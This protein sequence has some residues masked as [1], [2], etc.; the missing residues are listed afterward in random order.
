[1]ENLRLLRN[2]KG[3]TIMDLALE[4][5]VV[6]STIQQYETGINEPNIEMLIKLADYFGVTIDY[7]VGRSPVRHP[8]NDD[9]ETLAFQ[10]RHLKNDSA[11]KAAIA[12]L[13]EVKQRDNE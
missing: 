12:L 6:Q 10:L 5:D 1:M 3:M 13:R 11:K 4:M 7:L 8:L 9:D 2:E